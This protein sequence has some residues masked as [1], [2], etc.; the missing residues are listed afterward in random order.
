[1]ADGLLLRDQ[2]GDAFALV[3]VLVLLLESVR[4][5]I[6]D[7]DENE[8]ESENK[9]AFISRKTE[10]EGIRRIP[11]RTRGTG[12]PHPSLCGEVPRTRSGLTST[13]RPIS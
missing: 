13:T 10:N 3:L 5:R 9:N 6:E 4:E 7:E 1:M 8:D 12:W 11:S 2:R